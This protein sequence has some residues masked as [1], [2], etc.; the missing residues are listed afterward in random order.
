MTEIP[1]K[2]G[3]TSSMAITCLH[4]YFTVVA[5]GGEVKM[6]PPHPD[7]SKDGSAATFSVTYDHGDNI[8]APDVIKA[9][10]LMA[11]LTWA[12]GTAQTVLVEKLPVQEDEEAKYIVTIKKK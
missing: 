4:Q 12:V 8:P 7:A 2:I 1:N 10:N 5:W 9:L 6:S 11:G 3:N